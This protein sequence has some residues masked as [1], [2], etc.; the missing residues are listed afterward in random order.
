MRIT[1]KEAPL[2][3]GTPEAG[4]FGGFSGI[5][6]TVACPL[7][8][9]PPEPELIFRNSRGVGFWRCPD[10]SVMYA[11]PRFTR[12]SLLN[13]YEQESFVDYSFYEDW[14]Y[15]KWKR[16]N[17]NRSYLT[18]VLKLQLLGRFLTRKD[19]VLDVGCGAGLFLVEAQRRGFQVAGIEPSARLVEIGN[20]VLNVPVQRG[21]LETF[22]PGHKYQGM[23]VWDVLEHIPDPLEMLRQCQS[24][25][26]PEGYLF[27]QVPNYDGLSNRLKTFMCRKRLRKTGFKHFGFPGHLYS[28]NRRS[29][30]NLLKAGGFTPLVFESWSRRLKEG[31]SGWI[32]YLMKKFCLSD[33]ITCAARRD[34]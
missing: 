15:Q 24:L 32:P 16:E 34:P 22:D 23:V 14:S 29:L 25:L 11:S 6:E 10:C 26:D 7:C 3:T 12:E 30:A 33:Y 13:I 19:L 9:V 18:Q 5:L 1:S 31:Y 17:R 8:D 4:K 2:E 21:F 20:R 28:F 27:V